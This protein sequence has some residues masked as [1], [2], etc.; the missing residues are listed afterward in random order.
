MNGASSKI[1][2]NIS[3]NSIDTDI[4]SYLEIY[5]TKSLYPGSGFDPSNK[6]YKTSP[7]TTLF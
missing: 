5:T 1:I 2:V 7:S 3:T 6:C 4:S